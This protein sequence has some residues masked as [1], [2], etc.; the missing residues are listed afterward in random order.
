MRERAAR[1][2]YGRDYGHAALL[3]GQA[4]YYTQLTRGECPQSTELAVLAHYCQHRE[5]THTHANEDY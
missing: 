4:E 3:Y 5:A 1:C 2:L